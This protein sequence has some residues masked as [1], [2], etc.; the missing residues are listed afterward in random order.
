MEDLQRDSNGF[1]VWEDTAEIKLG[2][3]NDI[4]FSNKTMTSEE[5]QNVE[6]ENQKISPVRTH[7]DEFDSSLRGLFISSGELIIISGKTGVGKTMFA[8]NMAGR[9]ARLVKVVYLPIE[10]N[11][12]NIKASMIRAYGD[13]YDPKQERIKVVNDVTA[14][15]NGNAKYFGNV[16]EGTMIHGAKV[17]FVDL[18]TDIVAT[19]K[20]PDKLEILNSWLRYIE[21]LSIHYGC[22]VVF[23]AHVTKAGGK[24]GV[25]SKYDII[26]GQST[27]GTSTGIILVE[28][29]HHV[30]KL[31]NDG[32]MKIR[33]R[34][35]K[36]RDLPFH[37]NL[38]YGFIR[39]SGVLI[40]TDTFPVSEV[41]A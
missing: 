7:W 32:E 15:A 10:G 26:G 6:Y 8:T 9:L 38:S 35:D 17:V 12:T 4:G 30:S 21:K 19:I 11:A 20:G 29:D 27:I 39:E 1:I 31:R 41:Q 36:R 24:E 37:R 22:A 5:A 23:V 2:H 18:L 25:L 3:V 40:P 28:P 33:V 13:G 16:I 14:K 34:V